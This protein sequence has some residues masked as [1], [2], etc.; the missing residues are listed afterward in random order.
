MFVGYPKGTRGGLSYSHSEKKVFT[1]TNATFLENDY[2]QNF[3][4]RSKVVL[5]EM[6]KE[7]TPTNVPSSSTR[8]DDEIPTFHVQPMQVG[9]NEESTIVLSKQSRSLVVVGGFLETQFSMVWMV[10]PIWLLVTLVTMI[11]CLSNKQWLALKRN[12]GSKP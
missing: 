11:H 12:Y 1:S 10:K 5:E 6:V 7:L 8:V 9:L 3:K 4:P 2:V